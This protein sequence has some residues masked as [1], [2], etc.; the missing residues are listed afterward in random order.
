[1]VASRK[2]SVTQPTP[3]AKAGYLYISNVLYII[4]N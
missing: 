2:F 4:N 3:A 1:M